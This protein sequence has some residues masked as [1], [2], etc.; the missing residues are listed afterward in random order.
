MSDSTSVNVNPNISD[1]FYRYKMPKIAC[2]VEG[3]GN[4]IKTVIPNIQDVARALHRRS[5]YITKYFGFELGSQTIVGDR[6]IVNGAHDAARLQSIL[7]NF[8]KKFVLCQKCDNPETDLIVE[9]SKKRQVIY[10]VCVACGHKEAVD[11]THKLTTY[12]IRHPPGSENKEIYDEDE[13]ADQEEVVKGMGSMDI[14]DLEVN[15]SDKSDDDGDWTTD[16]RVDM[17]SN[18]SSWLQVQDPIKA[19]CDQVGKKDTKKLL[20]QLE[21]SRKDAI[22]GAVTTLLNDVEFIEKKLIE[23]HE[24]VWKSLLLRKNKLNKKYQKYLIVG[25]EILSS[26]TNPRLLKSVSGLLLEFYDMELLQ[27]SIIRK[28]YESPSKKFAGSLEK[29]K[30]VRMNALKFMEYLNDQE[31]RSTSSEESEESE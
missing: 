3:K 11:M 10:Q 8:I 30:Q 6:D 14:K 28:W 29:S 2:K 23:K 24:E 13:D 4:G 18:M 15:I 22:I 20:K 27:E 5:D 21:I 1:A 17:K 26:N 31:G 12:I 19:F 25:L 16:R 9:G 7:S